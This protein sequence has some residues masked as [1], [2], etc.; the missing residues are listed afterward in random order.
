VLLELQDLLGLP[1]LLIILINI[2]LDHLEPLAH[3]ATLDLREKR[4]ILVLLELPE[5]LD[6]KE[7]PALMEFPEPKERPDQEATMGLQVLLV[8]LVTLAQRENQELME[9]QA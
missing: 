9:L 4:E 1:E 7:S 2:L 5:H 3:K 6:L 8:L